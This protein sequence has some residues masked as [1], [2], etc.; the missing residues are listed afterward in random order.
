MVVETKDIDLA[1]LESGNNNGADDD[2]AESHTI[3]VVSRLQ[4]VNNI[5]SSI[6]RPMSSVVIASP[7]GPLTISCVGKAI[8]RVEFGK[9]SATVETGS[10][11]SLRVMK[12]CAKELEEYFNNERFT[13]TIPLATKGTEFQ[14]KIWEAMLRVPFGETISYKTLAHRA[15]KPEA[16]RAAASACGKNP[17][18]ILIPCHRIVA[19]DGTAGGYNGGLQKKR[20]LLNHEKVALEKEN[21]RIPRNAKSNSHRWGK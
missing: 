9:K 3:N 18:L 19:S 11:A 7:L 12:K 20:W 15:G 4:G 10:A 1:P 6:L 8:T 14:E 21:I 13:F 16:I 5:P 17:S 2:S